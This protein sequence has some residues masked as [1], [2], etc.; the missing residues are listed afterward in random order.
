MKNIGIGILIIVWMCLTVALALSIVGLF[1]I[2]KDVHDNP[3]TWM[4]FGSQLID[5]LGDR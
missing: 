4:K 3:S 2:C 5:I 1:V